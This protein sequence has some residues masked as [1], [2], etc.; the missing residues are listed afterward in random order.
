MV[1]FPSP[2]VFLREGGKSAFEV[3]GSMENLNAY[4]LFKLT[5]GM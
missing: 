2:A 5:G 1:G 4:V 3:T